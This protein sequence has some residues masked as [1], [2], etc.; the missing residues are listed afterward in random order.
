VDGGLA[1]S[2]LLLQELADLSGCTL[3]RAAETETTALGAALLAALGVGLL[4]NAAE[5]RAT[6]AKPA[7]ILPTLGATER[8]ARRARW[9]QVLGRV[10]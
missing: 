3:W 7:E 4:G 10:A 9:Q 5:A 2:D 8:D 1:Q 6:L